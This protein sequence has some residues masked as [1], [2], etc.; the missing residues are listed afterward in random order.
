MD[1]RWGIYVALC[2]GYTVAFF[3][4]AWSDGKLQKYSPNGTRT[5]GNFV[6][7]HSVFLLIVVALIWL[8][9]ASKPFLP[10]WVVAEGDHHESWYLMFGLLGMIAI[11]ISEQVVLS[12]PPA[13]DR[14]LST[15]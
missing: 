10:N 8:A 7:T 12:K 3:G 13:D 5:L 14:S 1:T 4:L 15:E 2:V 9:R 6:Q 11:F